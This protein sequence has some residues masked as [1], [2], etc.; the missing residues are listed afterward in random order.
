M[1]GEVNPQV[2]P[3]QDPNYLFWSRPVQTPES[4]KANEYALSTAGEAFKGGVNLAQFLQRQAEDDA[5][6]QG[7]D[8]VR[9]PF[10][11]DLATADSAIRSGK[12]S[13]SV[14]PPNPY[15]ANAQVPMPGVG[16][17]L[18]N[19]GALDILPTGTTP[20]ELPPELQA[21]PAKLETL[22][23]GKA[24]GRLSETDYYGRLVALAKDLRTRYPND[25]DYI[26]E[27]MK[28]VSGVD[29]ANAYVRGM[30]QDINSF[31]TA[32]GENRKQLVSKLLAEAWIPGSDMAIRRVQSGEWGAAEVAKFMNPSL[33]AFK[34]LELRKA[35]RE[36]KKGVDDS[37]RLDAE[38]EI[39]RRVSVIATQDFKN[40]SLFGNIS[41]E[42]AVQMTM[43]VASGKRQ[44]SDQEAQTLMTYLE[45]RQAAAKLS[46]R[47]ALL[48]GGDRSLWN[49]ATPAGAQKRVE[50]QLQ[51]T[52]GTVIGLLKDKQYG[53]AFRQLNA[54]SAMEAGD[55]YGLF[56][57]P[58]AALAST[59]R[60]SSLI[61]K[62][63][64][65]MQQ[66]YFRTLTSTITEPRMRAWVQSM[67]DQIIT[68]TQTDPTRPG[69]PVTVSQQIDEA[70]KKGIKLPGVY[71]SFVNMVEML[72]SPHTPD[73]EKRKLAKAFFDPSN[74][75]LITKFEKEGTDPVTGKPVQG[76]QYS[77]FARLTSPD[78]TQTMYK[79]GGQDWQNYS[80]WVKQS[81]GR[82]LL[83]PELKDL[84]TIQEDPGITLAWDSDNHRFILGGPKPRPE[85][86]SPFEYQGVAAGRTPQRI[87]LEQTINRINNGLAHVSEVA[88]SEGSD[89]NSYLLNW[90]NEM[91]SVDLEHLSGIPEKMLKAIISSRQQRE[92][93]QEELRKKYKAQ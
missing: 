63:P 32:Q 72:P 51:A 4:P 65:K 83:G 78:I 21:L 38:H 54:V 48:D 58:D 30:V 15:D 3:T 68:Q 35:L 89:V 39:D 52:Y 25:R 85:G 5:I 24:N 47:S 91:G 90:I 76:G 59:A 18:S 43:E 84:R 29:S 36:D 26:D 79:L 80:D 7:V 31:V 16:A 77:V 87:K 67:Q 1:A 12:L 75:G 17:G 53:L 6:H 42:Q 64:D 23:G 71:S 92:Q 37:D 66:E 13:T 8:R 70:Q 20:R 49:L 86:S 14:T 19:S 2:Q 27:K 56:T 44:L 9:D 41:P 40:L 74:L 69:K 45:S 46:I 55:R 50:D 82:E 88:K 73:N 10:T 61:S 62:M 33:A 11:S 57:N 81:F 60:M 93:S 22:D 28:A 34:Q